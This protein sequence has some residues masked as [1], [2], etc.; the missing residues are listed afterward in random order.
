MPGAR[1]V[2]LQSAVAHVTVTGLPPPTGVAV[3]VYGPDMPVLGNI[4]AWADVGLIATVSVAG[5]LQSMQR[6]WEWMG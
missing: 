2:K 4:V 3:T 1:P 5:V 6:Q